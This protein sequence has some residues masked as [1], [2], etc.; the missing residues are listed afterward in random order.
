MNVLIVYAHPEPG[1]F[2]GALKDA[3]VAA[4]TEAGHQVQVSDLYAM[5]FDPVVRTEQFP[6]RAEA[7]HFHL[8]REQRHA[9]ETGSIAADVAAEHAKLL[10]AD[11]IIFQFP[12]WWGSM[13]AI[14]KGWIDR[15]FSVGTVYGRGTTA[16]AGKKVLLSVTASG[17]ESYEKGAQQVTAELSHVLNNMFA[18]PQFAVLEPFFAFGAGQLDDAGRAGL[19]REFQGRVLSA[20]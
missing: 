6:Q 8:Q 5:S 14:M 12:L 13:P 15:V 17:R 4:L 11:L 7:A 9:A 10:W 3:A 16:L 19:L 20:G 1:S 2:N 18:F